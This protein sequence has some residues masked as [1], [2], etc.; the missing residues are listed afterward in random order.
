MALATDL[1]G[2]GLPSRLAA[3]IAVGGVGAIAVT[4]AG[5]AFASATRIRGEQRLAVVTGAD[6]TTAVSLPAVSGDVNIGDMFI[7]HNSDAADSLQIYGSSGV[8]IM[9]GDSSSVI[10]L[11]ARDTMILFP[12]STSSWAGGALNVS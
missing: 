5:S 4:A 8:T 12:V 6:G 11:Q 9:A 3:R 2:L 1:M 10:N 7:I